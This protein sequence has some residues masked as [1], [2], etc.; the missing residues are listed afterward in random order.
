MQ[1]YI[2]RKSVLCIYLSIYPKIS[3]LQIIAVYF[4]RNSFLCFFLFQFLASAGLYESQEEA[5]LREEVL[6]RLDQVRQI[7]DLEI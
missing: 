7:L 6:G 5:V 2:L 1:T 4:Q 3:L